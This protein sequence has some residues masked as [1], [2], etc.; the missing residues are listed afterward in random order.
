M[1]RVSA[2]C[3]SLECTIFNTIIDIIKNNIMKEKDIK[4]YHILPVQ[5]VFADHL[6]SRD[7]GRIYHIRANP[8]PYEMFSGIFDFV[9]H[10]SSFMSINQQL[11]INLNYTVKYEITFEREDQIQVI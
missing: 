2:L 7:T 8:D 6:I 3:V 11:D 10:A 9:H 1:E 5:M 4:K